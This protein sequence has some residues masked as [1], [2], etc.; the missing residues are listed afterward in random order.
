MNIPEKIILKNSSFSLGFLDSFILNV[1]KEYLE[2]YSDGY[3]MMYDEFEPDDFDSYC[4]GYIQSVINKK[5]YSDE[6][7]DF[8]IKG[9]YYALDDAVDDWEN[10][11]NSPGIANSPN[12]NI[13]TKIQL[14]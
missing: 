7:C 9:F 8:Y 12:Q 14:H 2:G 6:R 11:M 1:H 3:E 10:E 13:A 4:A 5:E